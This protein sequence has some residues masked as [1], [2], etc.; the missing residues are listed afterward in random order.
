MT[1]FFTPTNSIPKTQSNMYDTNVYNVSFSIL[2]INMA[3]KLDCCYQQESSHSIVLF[4]EGKGY[5]IKYATE[6]DRDNDFIRLTK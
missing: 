2:H 3:K 5:Q 6:T 1:H 4:V